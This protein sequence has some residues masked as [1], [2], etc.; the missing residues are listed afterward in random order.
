MTLE[1][2]NPCESVRISH[3]IPSM[4]RLGEFCANA[5]TAVVEVASLIGFVST[6]AFGVYFEV[7]TLVALFHK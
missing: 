7:H 5:K 6:V 1:V 3:T 4:K 2:S